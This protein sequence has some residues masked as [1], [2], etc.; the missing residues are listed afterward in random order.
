[1]ID[2]LYWAQINGSYAENHRFPSFRC[3]VTP[4][5]RKYNMSNTH[6][7]SVKRLCQ[8]KYPDKELVGPNWTARSGSGVFLDAENVQKVIT[9]LPKND[10]Q[11][12]ETSQENEKKPSTLPPS[13]SWV[14]ITTLM[15]L[16][17]SLP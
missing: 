11:K 14:K 1:M 7:I 15:F 6:N 5:R 2:N 16:S 17:A 13:V 8:G 9:A 10:N 3:P 4:E 12:I